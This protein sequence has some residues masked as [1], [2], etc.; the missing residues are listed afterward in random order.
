MHPSLETPNLPR[1]PPDAPK[2]HWH[3]L[4]AIK[5]A[6]II[7]VVAAHSGSPGIGMPSVYDAGFW[8]TRA[9]TP[10]HVPAFLVVSGFLYASVVGV[11]GSVIRRRL[12]RV[13]MPYLVA[14]F[15]VM[16]TVAPV[17]NAFVG[18][19]KLLTATTLQIYYYVALILCLI[20]LVWPLSR[21]PRSVIPLLLAGCLALAVA[22]VSV[23]YWS[24]PS[25]VFWGMRNIF[26]H[27]NLGYFLLGWTAALY[28]PALSDR[29]N[30]YPS[31]A[32]LFSVLA[33]LF[34]GAV[35]AGILPGPISLARIGYTVGVV[36]LLALLTARWTPPPAVLILANSSLSIYLFHRVF[37]IW[38]TPLTKGLPEPLQILGQ[39]AAGLGGS[40]LLVML[41]QR[42]IGRVWSRRI[43]G[44]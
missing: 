13:L 29:V 23:P 44:A 11:R 7:A 10:F 32:L 41:A 4:D 38:A 17:P 40:I 35:H 30:R 16:A 18:T 28:L 31:Q 36:S 33:V 34:F 1:M 42:T 6:A 20:I 19:L 14:S 15:L 25:D 2:P 43:L 37:Q 3:A 9:W 27:F 5:A 21:L 26:N 24:A 39:F 8:M 22:R 12:I